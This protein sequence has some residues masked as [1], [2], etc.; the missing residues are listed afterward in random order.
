PVAVTQVPAAL[1]KTVRLDD[2]ALPLVTP[3]TGAASVSAPAVPLLHTSTSPHA[4]AASAAAAQSA[5][6]QSAGDALDTNAARWHD[7][8]AARIQW[9]RH[10]RRG[11]GTAK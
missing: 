9:L 1:E 4:T 3:T 6:P 2:D 10:H 7:A 5:L 8:L 11:G